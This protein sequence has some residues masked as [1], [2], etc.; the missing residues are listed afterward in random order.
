MQLPTAH[1][2]MGASAIERI[3]KCPGSV[4][5]SA[6]RK[7]LEEADYT[8]EGTRAHGLA[9]LALRSNVETWTLFE[10]GMPDDMVPAVDQ[11][12]RY[13]QQNYL[14]R[15]GTSMIE[16]KFHCPTIHPLFYGTSDFVYVSGD[17]EEVTVIDYKHGAGIAVDAE[18]N[19]QLRY[20]AA[21]AIETLDLWHTAKRVYLKIIQPRAFHPAGTIRTWGISVEDLER[22]LHDT[23]IP[24]MTL[25]EHSTK[26]VAGEHCRF[27]PVRFYA[28][29]ALLQT[30][31]EMEDL[32]VKLTKEKGAREISTQELA[33]FLDL[34]VAFKIAHKAAISTATARLQS[35]A[36]IPGWKLAKA[37][38]NREFKEGAEAAAEKLF[39]EKAYTKPEF[40]S[41]A[42]IDKLPGGEDF[43]ARWAEK[44]DKGLTLAPADD[45]RPAVNK[46]TKSLFKPVPK[47]SN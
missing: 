46:D 22:W 13:I 5:L 10:P 34:G 19:D 27:C 15:N 38:S 39:G 29:P 2:P 9:E 30:A 41:P 16:Q 12:V 42:E 31:E 23:L 37:R 17:G 11:Y 18:E 43:T 14:K 8:S 32:V 47:K 40:K 26:T 1:S 4:S 3:L 7:E 28:C 44:P 45:S 20:Y 36:S 24:G 25:A 33:K 35:G 21:G 6:G